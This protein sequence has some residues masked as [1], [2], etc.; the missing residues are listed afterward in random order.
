MSKSRDYWRRRFELLIDSEFKKSESYLAEME[1]A[2]L[3]AM[4]EIEKDI[5][6]WYTRF[7][8]NNNISLAEARKLLKTDELNELKWSVD[9]Y[10]RFG[11]ENA[12][13]QAWMKELEN[14]SSRVHISRLES[15]R[16]QLQQHIEA[17]YGK[18][19]QDVER[20]MKEV[21]QEQYYHVAFE[22]QKGFEVAFTVQA[23]DETKLNYIINKPWTV[24]G[25]TFSS[26][27]WRD[28]NK[29]VDTLYKELIQTFARGEA[30]DRMIHVVS[31]T[32]DTSRKNAARLVMTESAFFSSS[33]QK[34]AFNDLD[35]E[36]YEIV[37][38][39]DRKTSEV[40]RSLDG[41]VLN[42]SEY[43]PGVTANPFHPWCR[44]TTVP[45]FD[46]NY[47]ERIAR[48]DDGTSYYV[49]SNMT[50]KE[51]EKKYVS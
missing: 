19:I 42:M 9:E 32:L 14:A 23:L 51:W 38:T 24:D 16:L 22:I 48:A 50:Y 28:K 30:P 40:C 37:A 34:T 1:K 43:E 7:A 46:D 26:K 35:V 5:T 4:R 21:Y 49:S 31:K 36:R 25:Q 29:L 33:A 44:T 11:E 8:T 6:R 39:L 18:Q 20:L 10:I 13:N 15:L 2:Y 17:L 3:N 12:I 41:K 27:L 45:Y 47:G